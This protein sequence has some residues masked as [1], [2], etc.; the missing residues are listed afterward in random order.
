M[1]SSSVLL[2]LILTLYTQGAVSAFPQF[3]QWISKK[4]GFE[5]DCSYCHLNSGGPMGDGSGQEGS[6]TDDEKSKLHTKDSPVLNEFGR[7]LIGKLGYDRVVSGVSDPGL[8]AN[9]MKVYDLDG[10][11]VSDGAEMEHGSL[12]D[13]PLSAPPQLAW[14]HRLSAH[15]PFILTVTLSGFAAAAGL[16]GL[17]TLL[18][19]S[20]S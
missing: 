13:D 16:I 19:E 18:K 20:R 10:D 7:Q 6:L 14:F 3:Q 17:A 1:R 5:V 9:A 12:P 2:A 4:A 8:V 11:G 15:L